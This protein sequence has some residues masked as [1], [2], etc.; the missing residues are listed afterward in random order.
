MKR[1]IMQ[2]CVTVLMLVVM[3]IAG[4]QPA[5]AY[6]ASTSEK[7]AT[8]SFTETKAIGFKE[9]NFISGNNDYLFALGKKAKGNVFSYSKDGV[10]FKDVLLDTEITKKFPKITFQSMEIST[11]WTYT[12]KGEM[13]LIGT[14]KVKEGTKYPFLISISKDM[15]TVKVTPFQD[16]I[17][18]LDAKATNIE[19]DDYFITH[20]EKSILILSGS[21]SNGSEE[22][23]PYYLLSTKGADFKAYSYPDN[24]YDQ[25]DFAGDYLICSKWIVPEAAPGQGQ[26]YYST[27]YIKWT[28]AVT[29]ENTDGTEWH[30]SYLDFKCFSAT[31]G[32]DYFNPNK[33]YTVYY[34]TDMKKYKTISKDYVIEGP[35]RFM[36]IYNDDNR[37]IAEEESFGETGRIVI[38]QRAIADNSEWKTLLDYT[39]KSSDF[40]FYDYIRGDGYVLVKDGK[41]RKIFNLKTGKNYETTID[42]DK[43]GATRFDETYFYALYDKT[44]L[45]GTKNGF[46]TNYMFTTPEA[47]KGMTTWKAGKTNRYYFYSNTK[48]YYIDKTSLDSKLK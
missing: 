27:D 13:W 40:S 4:F 29:P 42:H 43:L 31:L 44:T 20:W 11:S 9:I 38:S 33:T 48:I 41:T 26:F 35:S 18:K 37:Y 34:T 36:Y 7:K 28:K 16:L 17:K 10:N 6:A 23:I 45:L 30:R 47:M 39:A 14:G 32:E 22:R 25:M 15:K 19:I 21:Y 8:V 2:K 12:D 5:T 1:T 3:V 46:V 24:R